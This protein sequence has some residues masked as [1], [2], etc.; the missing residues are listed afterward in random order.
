[1]KQWKCT[2][3]GYIHTGEE[4]PDKCPVC[5]ADKSLFQLLSADDEARPQ[6]KVPSAGGITQW[7]CTVCGY[8]HTGDA[9]PDKCPVCG[10]DKSLF[11]PVQAA[12]SSATLSDSPF[13]PSSAPDQRQAED[14]SESPA[15]ERVRRLFQVSP[16]ADLLKQV[17]KFHGHPIAVHIPNGL[18]PVSVLFT[19]LA[20]LFG[21]EGFATAAR[22]NTYIVTLAMPIVLATGLI[23][24]INRFNGRMT[25]V[26]KVKMICGSIVTLLSLLLSIWWIVTPDVYSNS[27]FSNLLFFLL[28]IA[29]LG[30]AGL[31]GWYGG[32]LVFR[33]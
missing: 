14:R 8:V 24:W 26:F 15:V 9:P 7:R 1:M 13:T 31:A 32:K 22:F 5:G 2:V 19:V 6:E 33:D 17:T 4:P 23:D 20:I 10:A 29:N 28:N 30:T 16:Y 21:S 25:K 12:A 3:C 11:E 18:L 27:I